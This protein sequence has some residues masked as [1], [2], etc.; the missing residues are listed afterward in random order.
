ML[1]TYAA[2][3]LRYWEFLLL[4][5][6]LL[7]VLHTLFTPHTAGSPYTL[8]IGYLGLAIEATLPLPQ[9]LANH[10]ARACKGVRG[11]VLA[12]WLVGV[13]MKMGVFLL[14]EVCKVAWAFKMCGV[15]QACCDAGLGAQW[16]IF[17][18]GGDERIA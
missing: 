8:L 4:L 7:A 13:A 11:A 12:N 16:W 18:D 9:I 17:G 14:S 5:T 1:I 2:P 3:N 10:R 15:F 6:L